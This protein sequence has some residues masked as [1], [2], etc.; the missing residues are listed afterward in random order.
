[1]VS[2]RLVSLF[3]L[4][5]VAQASSH[6]QEHIYAKNLDHSLRAE[7]LARR[8]NGRVFTLTDSAEGP[9]FFEYV[10]MSPSLFFHAPLTAWQQ[11]GFHDL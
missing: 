6:D 1:M 4:A 9:D 2:L 10:A 11:M 7:R 3:F 8:Q 5:A